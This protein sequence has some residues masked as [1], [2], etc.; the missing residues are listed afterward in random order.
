MQYFFYFFYSVVWTLAIPILSLLALTIVPK[1]RHGL[2]YK[3][4]YL[5]PEK[6][7]KPSKFT[8]LANE[9]QMAKPIW[10]HAVSVG[11]LNALIPLLKVFIGRPLLLSVSTHTAYKMA[12]NKLKDELENNFIRLIYMPWDHPYIINSALERINPRAIILMESEIWPAL[13][14]ESYK[15]K[16]KVMIVN[17]KLSDSSYKLYKKLYPL[18]GWMF[19]KLSLILV[20]S[21]QDSRKYIDMK[22]DK[23][24]IFMTGNM[25]FSA[26]PNVKLERSAKL[27][28]LLGYKDSH[29]VWVCGSTHPEEETLLTAI[30]QELKAELPQ[31]RLIL[32]PRH[33]E[34]F[35]VVEDIINSAARLTPI[36][37]S[38]IKESLLG[39]ARYREDGTVSSNLIKLAEKGSTIESEKLSL[40][41]VLYDVSQMSDMSTPN[42]TYSADDVLLIDTI[43]DLMDIYSIA[44]I[45]FVGGT[46][47]ETVGGHNVLEPAACRVPVII[48]PHYYKNTAMVNMM[49]EADALIIA[50]TKEDLRLA[51]LELALNP[52]KRILMGSEA[53][54]LTDRNKRIVIDVA[55]LLKK[56]IY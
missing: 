34:R 6:F 22:I 50:E 42:R 31:L 54:N 19:Q 27:R 52:D 56:E 20:Q 35:G 8:K 36:R 48:G 45:A 44:D 10:F 21:P 2:K 38:H 23:N 33:P 4:G 15:R 51:V 17:A 43:G 37:L 30:F 9:D 29:I 1:W 25:K 53:K 14:H 41:K 49:D 18:I 40:D 24:R 55:E 39:Y 47:N 11:E 7:I 32:A 5:D 28:S 13:I 46:I 3:L 26:L 16:I 12:E